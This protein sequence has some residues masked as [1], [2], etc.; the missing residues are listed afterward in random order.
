MVIMPDLYRVLHAL[1]SAPG[2]GTFI[3]VVLTWRK[4]DS[5]LLAARQQ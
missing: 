2:P 4:L 3:N 1:F 5:L